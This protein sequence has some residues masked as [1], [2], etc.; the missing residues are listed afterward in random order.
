M[1]E[2]MNRIQQPVQL[3]LLILFVAIIALFIER[4]MDATSDAMWITCCASVLFTA[5][6]NPIIGVF[7]PNWI[8]H[9]LLS[10][11][12]LL[13]TL[14]IMVIITRMVT[15][16]NL[17]EVPHYRMVMV[18]ALVF[19]VMINGLARLLERRHGDDAMKSVFTSM[20]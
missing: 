3:G 9:F 16:M 14:V 20:V 19:F 10:S 17:N 7:K 13:I 5:I 6:I 1:N 8:K 2:Q 11:G 15:E 4:Q 18:S 12:M